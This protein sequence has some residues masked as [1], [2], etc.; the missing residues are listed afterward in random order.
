VQGANRI[1]PSLIETSNRLLSTGYAQNIR[2][3]VRMPALQSSDDGTRQHSGGVP[4]FGFVHLDDASKSEQ[5][6]VT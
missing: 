5:P 4:G 3:T 2:I 1:E 6:M